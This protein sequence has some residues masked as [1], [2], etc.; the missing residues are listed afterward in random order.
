E[1]P[2]LTGIHRSNALPTIHMLRDHGLI[3]RHAA[4]AKE[5]ALTW[6]LTNSGWAAVELLRAWGLSKTSA[7]SPSVAQLLRARVPVRALAEILV[8]NPRG[9]WE[10]GKALTATSGQD[11]ERLCKAASLGIKTFEPRQTLQFV[12]R[13]VEGAKENPRGQIG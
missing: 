10:V 2:A 12:V 4:D 13:M 6:E 8:G 5:T 1:V 9:G 11:R 7:E 3:E